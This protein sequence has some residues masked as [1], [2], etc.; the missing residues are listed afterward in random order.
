M[1]KLP[2]GIQDFENLRT[3]DYLYVDK[4]E[5]YFNVFNNGVFFFLSRPRRFGKSLM[6]STLKYLYQGKKELFKG[7]WIEDKWDWDKTYPVIYIDIND[8]VTK[9]GADLATSLMHIVSRQAETNS[10]SLEAKDPGNAFRELIEKLGSR[11][12]VVILVDEY[13]KPITDYIEFPKI[14]EEHVSI[15]KSFYGALKSK[16]HF[17]HKAI[18]SGVSK[19]GKVSIFSELN[20]LAD[21]TLSTDSNT[22]CGYTQADLEHYFTEY[23]PG[24]MKEYQLSEKELLSW[25]KNWY[26]GYSWNGKAEETLYNPFSI[27]KLFYYRRFANYWFET[28]TPSFLTHLLARDK[29]RPEQLEQLTTQE[30]IFFSSDLYNLDVISLL[31]QTGY[32]TIKKVILHPSQTRFILAYPNTEVRLSFTNYIL[33]EYMHV[34]ATSIG[35]DIVIN[36][37]NALWEKNWTLFFEK[38]NQVF[39]AVPY[40]LFNNNEAYYHSLV[41][42]MLTLTGHLVLSELMSNKGRIDTVLETDD[43]IVIFEFKMDSSA[44]AALNQIHEKNYAERYKLNNKEILLAGVNFDSGKRSVV[45]WKI[46]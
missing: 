20:N 12:K 8:A 13:D 37:Q 39:A 10:I 7:L 4:T 32:L 36:L 40:K 9:G 14:S 42:V 18:I 38:I 25:I 21:L 28:G 44:E 19:Y 3:G 5:G 31:V 2:I 43:F 17:I 46:E 6:L 24:L 11:E 15:L 26:N 23:F 34:S 33:A 22:I 16:D 27:L 1:K 29:I 41:H 35:T 45:D 30:T